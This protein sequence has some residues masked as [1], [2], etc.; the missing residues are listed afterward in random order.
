MQGSDRVDLRFFN[1]AWDQEWIDADN[2]VFEMN[3]N[4]DSLSHSEK[5]TP[6]P[7]R[8]PKS[9]ERSDA[10]TDEVMIPYKK[11]CCGVEKRRAKRDRKKALAVDFFHF[12][13]FWILCWKG[14]RK[15]TPV[16][17]TGQALLILPL[18]A[19]KVVKGSKIRETGPYATIIDSLKGNCFEE[20][21]RW[22]AADF[23]TGTMI[24]KLAE[25]RKGEDEMMFNWFTVHAYISL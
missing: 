12:F 19:Q 13:Q 14:K 24:S 5:A 6:A 8:A 20:L 4:G 9:S 10:G 2:S 21:P 11:N 18:S 22:W 7:E 3:E 23:V 17:E 16:K 25:I 15:D 1:F